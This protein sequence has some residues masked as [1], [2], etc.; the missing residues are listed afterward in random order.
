MKK[1][2]IIY[3][4]GTIGMVF[5][6][7]SQALTPFNFKHIFLHVPEVKRLDYDIE[8]NS[9]NPLID[10]SNMQPA[11][12]IEIAKLIYSNYKKFDGFVILHGSDTMAYTASALSFMLEN[13]NKPV[14]LTGSQLPIGEIRTDAK[15]N[16]I[17]AIEIA[18]DEKKGIP[19]V[20]EVCIYFDYKLFR[21][22]RCS[23]YNSEKFEA[24]QSVN[25]PLLAEAGVQIKY[26]EQ[27]IKKPSRKKLKLHTK[28]APQVGIL[29]IFPGMTRKWVESVLNAE[30]LK[31]I[32]L[33]T[34]GS[35]NA[36][37]EDWFLQTIGKAIE[38]NILVYNVTQCGGGNVDQ[39]K[40]ETSRHLNAMGV[41][42]GFDITTESALAKL[43]MLLGEN[44]DLKKV[45]KLL[46]I[47]IAGEISVI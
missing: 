20:P 37:T 31:A 9:F 7:P 3:T 11:N 33:E 10:S 28:L 25:Y 4:G 38:K 15:E 29:K 26:N 5:D 45:E 27:F 14:V 21:G 41:V 17:T 18:A 8:V 24:F 13:L 22:N 44:K 39:G 42:S 12:W 30:E 32:V 1:I 2:L 47:P 6:E 46:Q 34:F 35:G 36:P 16:L 40:Y 19:I 43:M 23:K